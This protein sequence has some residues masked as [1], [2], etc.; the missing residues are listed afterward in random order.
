MKKILHNIM[1]MVL[2]ITICAFS[3]CTKM[4]S[5]YKNYVVPGGLTY[6]GKANSPKVFPGLYRVKIAWLR[7]SDPSVTTAK[8]FWNNYLDSL[9][10]TIPPTGDSISVIINNLLEKPYAFVI[11]TY[12]GKGNKSI[13][14]EVMGGSYGAK[15]QAQLLT[16]PVNS[17]MVNA[18]GKTTIQWGAADIANGAY[19]SEVRYTDTL[20]NLK[21]QAFPTNVKTSDILDLHPNT[22]YQYRTMFKPDSISI[23]NFYTPY[24][25]SGAF[26]FDKKDWRIVSYSDQY[27]GDNAASFIIDGIPEATRWH[28]NGSA[29]PHWAIIDMGAVRTINKFGVWRTTVDPSSGDPRAPILIQF[30][31]SMDNVTWT[32]LGRF[33]FNN[34][35]NGEQNFTMP[36][37]SIGRYFKFVGLAGQAGNDHYM[38]L[39]EISAYGF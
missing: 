3:A 2:F 38:T 10:V 9:I 21:T 11:I 20:G 12:D 13:P 27:N 19:A 8:V 35:I 22:S 29:Y 37:S 34:L 25:V 32:D 39:G 16:Q 7:G 36:A 26:N 28:S 6:S 30:L 24:S 18:Q 5:T 33:N 17:T 1:I 14:V 4:D 23:D 31:I 15:Y